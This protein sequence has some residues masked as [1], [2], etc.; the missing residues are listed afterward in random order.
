MNNDY[1]RVNSKDEEEGICTDTFEAKEETVVEEKKSKHMLFSVLGIHRKGGML[2]ENMKVPDIRDAFP[3]LLI[4]VFLNLFLFFVAQM[5]SNTMLLLVMSL[6]SSLILPLFTV[7]FVYGLNV[8]KNVSYVRIFGGFAIGLILYVLLDI[9][10]E[11]C[12]EL[13]FDETWILWFFNHL[14]DDIALFFG[15]MLYVKFSKRDNIF[16]IVL[17]VTSVYGGFGAAKSM[18]GQIGQ[19][20]TVITFGGTGSNSQPASAILFSDYYFRKYSAGFFSSVA[21]YSVF[22]SF[23]TFFQSIICGG[24]VAL[25]SSPVRADRGK[26]SSVYLLLL[27]CCVMNLMVSFNSTILFFGFILK[28]V[29]FLVCA[30]VFLKMF[31]Y[32]LSRANFSEP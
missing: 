6:T 20:M 4:A 1:L 28:A 27:L 10:K 24:I 22:L 23:M 12:A 21:Y 31:N 16:A 2:S 32:L 29:A 30:I 9:V 15:A 14:L 13:L 25:T 11:Y 26:E 5:T 8:M 19:L 3:V 17:L 18:E 7:Y